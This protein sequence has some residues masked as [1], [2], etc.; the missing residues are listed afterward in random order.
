MLDEKQIS[1]I[2]ELVLRRAAL[3]REKQ[4]RRRRRALYTL[5]AALSLA[6][7]GALSFALP[8]IAPEF[9]PGGAATSGTI[10][11]EASVG[12]YVLVGVAGLV[13]GVALTVFC[14]RLA[15]Q[16]KRRR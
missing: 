16:A 4:G 9:I 8:A 2:S 13:L 15:A 5:C 12:G 1:E 3:L 6:A 11:G 14:M 7:I 10:Y